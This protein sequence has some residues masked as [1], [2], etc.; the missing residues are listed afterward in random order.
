M[1][2]FQRPEYHN[3]TKGIAMTMHDL[4]K[5]DE[6]YERLEIGSSTYEFK[7]WSPIES[8][9]MAFKISLLRKHRETTISMDCLA[10]GDNKSVVGLIKI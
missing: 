6:L 2:P 10:Y 8:K 9:H 5:W 1:P 7:D 4:S 3:S